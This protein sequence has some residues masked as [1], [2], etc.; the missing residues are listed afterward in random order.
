MKVWLITLSISVQL[1]GS[2]APDVK[3]APSIPRIQYIEDIPNKFF[4]KR[5]RRRN[6]VKLIPSLS[7]EPKGRL[8]VHKLYYGALGYNTYVC[9]VVGAEAFLMLQSMLAVMEEDDVKCKVK[10]VEL[11]RHHEPLVTAD[12]IQAFFQRSDRIDAPSVCPG[13]GS[14]SH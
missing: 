11:L 5:L 10:L 14:N 8:T 9:T 13:C 6:A 7:V 4:F 3:S 1:F 12:D 2:A